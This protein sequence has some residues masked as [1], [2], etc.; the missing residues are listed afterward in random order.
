MRCLR[1]RA[2][3]IRPTRVRVKHT[4]RIARGRIVEVI[5]HHYY[6][7]NYA[8]KIRLILGF[9]GLSWRSVI[10]P[11]V[12]PKP[13]LVPLTAGYSKT[14][15]MQI[16]ADVFCDTRRIADELEAKVPEPSLY[17]RGARGIV[18]IISHWADTHLTLN[19]GRYLMGTAHEKWRPEFHADRAAMWGVPVDLDRMRRSAT[20]YRQQ[21]V[22]QLDW[23]EDILSDD[24]PFLMGPE[25]SLA[26]ISC[27][28]ILWFLGSGGEQSTDVLIPFARVR[29][30]IDRVSA[31]GHG[32]P[33]DMSAAEALE[34][35]RLA[36]PQS[37]PD[38]EPDNAEGLREGDAVEVRA[39]MAGRD[40]VVGKLHR[41]TRQCVAVRH[42]NDRVGEVVVHL[43]RVGYVVRP[44]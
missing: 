7:S 21:L 35:A 5:L 17:P 41:L 3:D 25:A 14:P 37:V 6:G 8:E 44:A 15:V 13:E 40:P 16:G 39:E 18:Q 19:G 28:H 31:I 20:R 36:K 1:A 29:A 33:T 9:K 12:A 24:R 2:Q 23:L 27:Q 10:I 30:W 22:A 42:S 38:V 4:A 32:K 34:C 11:D 26:D 43:H